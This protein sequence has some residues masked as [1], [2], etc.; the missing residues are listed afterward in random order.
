L[1]PSEGPAAKAKPPAAAPGAQHPAQPGRPHDALPGS[2][3]KA[4]GAPERAR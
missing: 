1:P 2:G 4:A 3:R